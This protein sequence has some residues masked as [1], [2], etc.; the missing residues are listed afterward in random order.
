MLSFNLIKI[1]TN[2]IGFNPRIRF[3]CKFLEKHINEKYID[4]V[5]LSRNSDLPYE[6]LLKY[7]HKIIWSAFRYDPEF[8]IPFEFLEK[9]LQDNDEKKF[10]QNN[11]IELKT[12]LHKN[13]ID[14]LEK[15]ILSYKND[16]IWNY[17][18]D[19]DLP[20]EFFEKHF[21]DKDGNDFC[22]LEKLNWDIIS[23]NSDIP[24]TFYEKLMSNK[25][26]KKYMKKIDWSRLCLQ[27]HIPLS[28]FQKI[29]QSKYKDYIDWDSLSKNKNIPY[30]FFE[31]HLNMVNFDHLS[32]HISVDFILKYINNIDWNWEI[33]AKNPNI[34]LSF[35]E[36]I[37]SSYECK[38]KKIK[39]N[40]LMEN[41]NIPYTFWEKYIP[42]W[43][44][45]NEYYRVNWTILCNHNYPTSF[46]KKYLNDLDWYILSAND[47]IPFEFF[48]EN[49][50]FPKDNSD[51]IR[52]DT[53]DKIPFP[54]F[55]EHFIK[56]LICYIEN[57]D[58]GGVNFVI[59]LDRF[60]KIV[61]RLNKINK[62]NKITEYV[63]QLN[64]NIFLLYKKEEREDLY[65]KNEFT[66]FF[67][68]IIENTFD[69][70]KYGV[71][72]FL[73]QDHKYAHKY[74]EK[75]LNTLD[76]NEIEWDH[77]LY[78]DNVPMSFILKCVEYKKIK[79]KD[80]LITKKVV[81]EDNIEE[82]NKIL[83]KLL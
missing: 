69:S 74:A 6:F 71:D 37:I 61:K 1:I 56:E 47:N 29:L 28:F 7:E 13:Y 63:K 81:Y 40:L 48:E 24:H 36:D 21:Q 8:N 41:E 83:L 9:Y 10:K 33:L 4:W 51:K 79:W 14:K 60:M 2:Y 5:K 43:K 54:V 62:L 55:K 25:L 57:N 80:L 64:L 72:F 52:W 17:I 31:K 59:R 67:E 30:Q 11:N 50:S 18:S 23:G 75:F 19:S 49:F 82:M 68:N 76:H 3:E 35:W 20:V 66:D 78:N 53:I 22:G 70:L 77:L 65:D 15:Y 44:K 42:L 39:W 27:K 46:F 58:D 16:C 38:N 34:P 32:S 73:F 12:I 26:T 45:R